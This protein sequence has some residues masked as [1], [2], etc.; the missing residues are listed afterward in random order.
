MTLL[1][2]QRLSLASETPFL[3]RAIDDVRIDNHAL[4]AEEVAALAKAE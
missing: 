4:T 1:R 3:L 2:N